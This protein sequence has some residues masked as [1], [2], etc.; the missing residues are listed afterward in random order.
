ME[1]M[2]HESGLNENNENRNSI[3]CQVQN[4]REVQEVDNNAFKRK[5]P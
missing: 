5:Y 3:M 4:F 1:R 2:G